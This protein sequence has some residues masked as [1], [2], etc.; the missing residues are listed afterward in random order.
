[1]PPQSSLCWTTE[2]RSTLS[3]AMVGGHVAAAALA[4]WWLAAGEATIR[5]ALSLRLLL[6][7]LTTRMPVVRSEAHVAGLLR[8][9]A[10]SVE[11][12][13]L[14]VRVP[15]VSDRRPAVRRGP[16]TPCL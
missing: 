1:M 3:A 12:T 5:R 9:V 13:A 2:P 10:A 16:P 8:A 14:E 7:R 15:A 4:G 11:R 6:P